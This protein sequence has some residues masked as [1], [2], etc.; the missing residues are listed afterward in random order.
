MNRTRITMIDGIRG[1]SLLGILLANL[2]IFQYG[3]WGKDQI[4]LFSLSQLDKG[5]YSFVKIFIEGSFMPIFTFL[6]GYSMVMM[7]ENLQ[8]KALKVKRHFVRR[9]ILLMTIGLLHGTFLWEGDILFFY[10]LMS[11]FLLLF[12]NRKKKTLFIWGIVLTLLVTALGFGGGEQPFEEQQKV[13]A[14][15]KET[16]VVYESGTYEEIRYHRNNE[17]PMDFD[18]VE[19]IIILLLAPLVI[20]PMFLFGMYAAKKRAF[21]EKKQS[22]SFYLINAIIFVPVGI[23]LKSFAHFYP[24]EMW[25]SASGLLGSMSL[26]FGYIFFFALIFSK[27]ESSWLLKAFTNVGKLSMTNYLMQT[28]ICTTIFYGYGLG[29][30]GKV[31]VLNSLFIGLFIFGCQVIASTV[32]LK[33]LKI[34]PF[35]KVNR[36]WTY[37]SLSGKPKVKRGKQVDRLENISV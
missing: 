3:F 11:L 13:E 25:T 36:I 33:F 8:R 7:K 14:Y 6:F 22:I 16:I 27:F 20:A 31:G 12:L 17:S 28:I 10:G 34:G 37:F 23:L 15:V 2:L 32:Y 29:L 9:A 5:A 26:S 19:L 35:E 4:D 24:L 1:F 30:F 18:S 21:T